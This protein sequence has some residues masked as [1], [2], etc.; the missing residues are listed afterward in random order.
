MQLVKIRIPDDGECA[1][2]FAALVRRF[3]VDAYRDN[4]FVVV[5][6]ALQVLADMGIRYE[7]LGRGGL[8]Y[9]QK[10]LRDSA[11]AAAQ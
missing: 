10:T 11:A 4:T 7:E 8:D 2:G 6:D 5:Q 3:R 1:R 9:A